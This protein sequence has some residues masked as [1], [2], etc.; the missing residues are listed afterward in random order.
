MF[1]IVSDKPFITPFSLQPVLV[2]LR[3]DYLCT[4]QSLN[5]FNITWYKDG[6]KA[7]NIEG[8]K[9]PSLSHSK[10]LSFDKVKKYHAGRYTCVVENEAGKATY[11]ADFAV[12]GRCL[13]LRYTLFVPYSEAYLEFNHRFSD[14]SGRIEII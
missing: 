5:N 3:A 2:G 8:I 9:V 12:Y 10:A 1:R 6:E 14:I 4:A 13:P 11:S 7:E